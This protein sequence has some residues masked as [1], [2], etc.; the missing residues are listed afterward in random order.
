MPVA[1][2]WVTR[3]L[4][5][6]YYVSVLRNVFLK[7][8]PPR[9]MMGDLAALVILATVLITLATRAFHKRLE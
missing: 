9:L 7:G 1:V 6:R 5:P 8:T 4:P 2:Q 3:I